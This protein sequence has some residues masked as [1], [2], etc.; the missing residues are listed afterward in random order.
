MASQVL[1]ATERDDVTIVDGSDSADRV[2]LDCDRTLDLE[3]FDRSG[4]GL[5]VALDA[6]EDFPRCA[7]SEQ[8][9]P[10]R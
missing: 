7:G 3:S 4:L 5:V 2:A 8:N 1:S 9:I 10:G 6:K